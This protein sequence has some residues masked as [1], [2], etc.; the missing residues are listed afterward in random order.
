MLWTWLCSAAV[1]A[2]WTFDGVPSALG[3]P[4]DATVEDS[5]HVLA[6]DRD[7]Q[8]VLLGNHRVVRI[9]AHRDGRTFDLDPF[10]DPFPRPLGSGWTRPHAAAFSDQGLLV[11]MSNGRASATC[12][13][14]A[15]PPGAPTGV[16][17]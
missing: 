5:T 4:F 2:P 15:G 6:A 7:G 16:C 3:G 11:S 10:P 1:A 13:R 14:W 8:R 17:W 12:A 9:L